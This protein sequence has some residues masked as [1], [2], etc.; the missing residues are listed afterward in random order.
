MSPSDPLFPFQAGLGAVSY[1]SESQD[2]AQSD[3][4]LQF[5]SHNTSLRDADT[6]SAVVYS[7]SNWYRVNDG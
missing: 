3:T 2:G 1:T 7:A 6:D 4:D 5:A